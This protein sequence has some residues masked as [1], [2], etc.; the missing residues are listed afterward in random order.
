MAEGGVEED[1]DVGDFNV[2]M[3]G[4]EYYVNSIRDLRKYVA[5]T[6]NPNTERKTQSSVRKFQDFVMKEGFKDKKIEEFSTNELDVLI[7]NW[8]VNSRKENGEEYE[9]DSLTALHRSLD[10]Y[11]KEVNYPHS[12]LTSALFE[13]SRKVITKKI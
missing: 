2:R 5:S 8:L 10:R 13:T 11:L 1:R 3:E 12:I 4:E 9:P 7:G 6:R